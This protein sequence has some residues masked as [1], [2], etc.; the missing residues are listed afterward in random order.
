[1]L[2]LMVGVFECDDC[3]KNGMAGDWSE[4]AHWDVWVWIKLIEG[5]SMGGLKN[6]R[7]PS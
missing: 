4:M 7:G 5:L 6:R 1:M 3:G 2:A